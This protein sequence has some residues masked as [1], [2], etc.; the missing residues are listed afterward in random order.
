M[1]S[2]HPYEAGEL[3]VYEYI[4]LS[5]GQNWT[6]KKTQTQSIKQGRDWLPTLRCMF[7]EKG[8][9]SVQPCFVFSTSN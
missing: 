2:Q 1:K 7:S 8:D 3:N 4:N 5:D 6:V 9:G